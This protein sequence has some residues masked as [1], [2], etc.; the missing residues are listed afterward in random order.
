MLA[1]RDEP[2]GTVLSGLI[3]ALA[4]RSQWKV[5]KS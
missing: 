5:A 4:A 3:I 2:G 1:S